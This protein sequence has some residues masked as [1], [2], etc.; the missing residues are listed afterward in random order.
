MMIERERGNRQEAYNH[1]KASAKLEGLEL[2]TAAEEVMQQY[3]DGLITWEERQARMLALVTPQNQTQVWLSGVV[4]NMK[5]MHDDPS[6]EAAIVK[7]RMD[8]S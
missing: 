1:A 4:Q 2:P 7:K 5:K 8:L 3:V 6:Y